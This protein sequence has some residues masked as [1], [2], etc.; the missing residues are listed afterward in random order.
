MKPGKCVYIQQKKQSI[1]TD[2][3][4]FPGGSVVKNQL[5]NAGDTDLNP[6]LGRSHVP[7]SNEAHA[8]LLSLCSRAQ[9]SQLPS[10]RT[11]TTEAHAPYSLYSATREATTVRSQHTAPRE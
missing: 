10:P 5:A 11:V 4:G 2:P 7:Q 8:Q 1:K 9:E 6:N 3:Q